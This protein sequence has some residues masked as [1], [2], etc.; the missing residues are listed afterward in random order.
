MEL[1]V[2]LFWVVCGI[3]SAVVAANKGRSGCGWFILGFLLGPFG[4]LLARV[5]SRNEQ[6]IEKEALA[7]GGMKKC[8]FCAELIRAEAR[9]CRYCQREWPTLEATTV[10]P[11]AASANDQEKRRCNNDPTRTLW[12]TEGVPTAPPA[13][14]LH[15]SPATD[16]RSDSVLIAVAIVIVLVILIISLAFSC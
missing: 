8:P 10:S 7:S 1:F 13:T 14:D 2:V 16:G 4:F 3:L 12:P 15:P 11:D 6:V 5:V 9:V